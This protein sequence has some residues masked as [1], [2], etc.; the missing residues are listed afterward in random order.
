MFLSLI[1]V[2]MFSFLLTTLEAAR[3]QGATAYVSMMTDLAGDSFL[4]GYYYP[5]FQNYR[6][7]GVDAGDEKAFF[8][9]EKLEEGI[10]ENMT[11]GLSETSGGLLRFEETEAACLQY[12]NLLENN[13]EAFYSQIKQQVVLD[14]LSLG[15]NRLFHEE[16]FVEAGMAG[17]IYKEQEEAMAVTATVTEELLKLM[18]LTDGIRME[19]NGIAF[20]KNGRLQVKEHFIKQPVSMTQ[21]EL[22]MRYDNEEVY[23][24]VS[25]KFYRADTAAK[26]IKEALSEAEWLENRI[27][28]AEYNI[29]NYN[30]ET[31]YL[32]SEY[33]AE[34]KRLEEEK[35]AD[36]T[37]L[38]ELKKQIEENEKLI[39]EEKNIKNAYEI[40]KRKELS[41]VNGSYEE[42]QEVLEGVENV[43]EDALVITERLE[44]KQ[45]AAKLVVEEYEAFLGSAKQKL[46]EELYEVF[47]KEL[48]KMKIYAGLDEKGFSLSL[49]RQ[50]LQNNKALLNTLSLPAFSSSNVSKMITAL[51]AVENRMEEYTT[52]GL[53]FSYGEIAAAEQTQQN[54][55]G[56]LT[57]LLTTG[58]LSLV[59]ISKEEVSNRSLS[60]KDL[61]SA[62]LEEEHILEELMACMKEVQ[63]L[64]QNGGISE[65][66]M[67]AGNSMLNGTALEIYSM[68]YFRCYG[69]ISPYT[70]LN[71]EREYLIFGK[72][73]DKSNLLSMVL[74]LAAIRTLLN[75]VMILKQPERVAQLETF[76]AGIAGFTGIPL[77]AAAIKYSILL[78]WSVEEA[79]VDTA[80]LLQGKRIAVVGLGRVSFHEIFSINKTV[81]E[82]KALQ[83]RD[84]SGAAY[85]DYLALVSLTKRA[86]VKAYRALD[87]IQ[88]N[89]RIRYRDS[90]RIRNTVTRI[91]FRTVTELQP[92]FNTGIFL[93]SVYKMQKEKEVAY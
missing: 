81:I 48:E 50:S 15:L 4:A 14:G 75:M 74:Y 16:Q 38:L 66:L 33:N 12:E 80:A 76:S 92:I 6:I 68:K 87:L 32:K 22:R 3:I 37:W 20:D 46:S 91:S 42:L 27:T 28:I 31:E 89:I 67:A 55:T 77:I 71:Y 43:L 51:S 65:V 8:S 61:P 83:C 18:E 57:E 54:V 24:A 62:G 63:E 85:A 17:E 35:D 11:F 41:S 39:M 40:R 9:R 34:K 69:E 29:W 86:Q 5:L 64:F 49:I 1:L 58:V 45:A 7:F 78:L 2:L 73:E 70:R 84:E 90:F 82:R 47:L 36:K 19:S 59:G 44:K 88:E 13:C 10:K 53:W 25:D 30:Q 93:P 26:Q 23:Y 79:L 52:D 21:S 72:N 60:G 56:F